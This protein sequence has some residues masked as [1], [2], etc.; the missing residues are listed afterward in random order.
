MPASNHDI[1]KAAEAIEQHLAAPRLAAA[2]VDPRQLCKV[3][4]QIKGPLGVL[5]PVI[6]LIPVYGSAVASGLQLLMN[7]ADQLCKAA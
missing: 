4:D 6:K 1:V 5:L 2:G 7:L 3:Y